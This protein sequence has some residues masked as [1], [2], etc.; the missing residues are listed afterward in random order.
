MLARGHGHEVVSWQEDLDQP[1]SRIDRPGLEKALLAVEHGD[2]DGIAVAK[3]DRFARSVAGAARLLERLERADGVLLAVDV[4]MDT[5]TPAGKLMRNVLMSLAEFELDRIRESWHDANINALGRG[6]SPG[7]PP[8]G[9]LR[10]DDGR[11]VVD[12]VAAPVIVELFDLRARGAAWSELIDLLDEKL[13]RKDGGAWPLPTVNDIISRRTYLGEISLG[14][15]VNASAHEPIVPLE[16]WEAAQSRE[17]RPPS[18]RTGSLLAGLLRCTACGYAMT[19]QGDGARGYVNYRCRGRSAAGVCPEPARISFLRADAYVTEKF[20][21]WA[22]DIAALDDTDNETARAEAT[23]EM[24]EA[25]LASYRDESIV[26]VLGVETYR[27]GLEERARRVDLARDEL[28]LLRRTTVPLVGRVTIGDEWPSL[29][30][31]ERRELLYAAID[32]VFVRRAHLGGR[33]PFEDRLHICWAGEGPA[34]LPRRGRPGMRP[35]SFPDDAPH[36]PAVMA[37]Q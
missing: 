29:D 9:Y 14:D 12:P 15:R 20:L 30:V 28:E 24:V 26:T 22:S 23:I 34:D 17:R 21:S 3:L 32:A 11:Y 25:E 19:Q 5:S 13:P 16:L 31:Y 2:A 18:R 36:P 1:G 10:G 35:F 6:V 33:A 27:A 8:V 37:A 4:G 7:T